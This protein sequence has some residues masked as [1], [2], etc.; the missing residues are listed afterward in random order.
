M[1]QSLRLFDQFERTDHREARRSEPTFEFMNRSAW[2]AC[3]NI[4]DVLEQWFES[5]PASHDREVSTSQWH[6]PSR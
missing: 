3:E 2:P 1:D 4:R 6:H 5:Y